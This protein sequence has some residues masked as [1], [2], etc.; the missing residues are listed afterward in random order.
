MMA[1]VQITLGLEGRGQEY[2]YNFLSA[3]KTHGKCLSKEGYDFLG[4]G[5]TAQETEA[6]GLVLLQLKDDDGSNKESRDQY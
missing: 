4:D 1:R 2:I 3:L 6:Q 5:H